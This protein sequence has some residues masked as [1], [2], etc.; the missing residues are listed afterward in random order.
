MRSAA[1]IM[2]E[3]ARSQVGLEDIN[4]GPGLEVQLHDHQD[5]SHVPAPRAHTR[6]DFQGTDHAV[7]AETETV[8]A[9]GIAAGTE[10]DLGRGN[11]TTGLA[12]RTG[13]LCPC[14][15]IPS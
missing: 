5:T 14:L 15:P 12:A 9:T 13:A 8:T 3:Q 6:N 4:H 1:K 7:V 11:D 2:N 10:G